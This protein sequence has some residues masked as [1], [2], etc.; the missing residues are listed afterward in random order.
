[1]NNGVLSPLVLL[2]RLLAVEFLLA[3]VAFKGSMVSVG[4]FV[5]L[6]HQNKIFDRAVCKVWHSP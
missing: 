6:K 2:H 3:D 5:D 4:S 1:M